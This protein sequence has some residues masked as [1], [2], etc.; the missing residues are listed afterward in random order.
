MS[1]MNRIAVARMAKVANQRMRR[2]EKAGYTRS[3]GYKEQ[4]A[5]LMQMGIAPTPSGARR[6]PESYKS[7]SED[8]LIQYEIRLEKI[9]SASAA[10]ETSGEVSAHNLYTV[11]GVRKFYN[12]VYQ[13]A[14]K[15]YGLTERGV[16]QEE[17]LDMWSSMSDKQRD[18]VYG[19][20]IYV[21]IIKAYYSKYR[22]D[23]DKMSSEEIAAAINEHRNFMQAL[24]SVGLSMK[25]YVNAGENE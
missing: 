25:D 8:E 20:D 14:D 16:S 12:D 21:R 24:S 2:L 23:A 9:A 22:D 3:P 13:T 6:F 10:A 4:Q 1:T 7:V 17:W 15:R 5:F 19:S 18:R 11:Q